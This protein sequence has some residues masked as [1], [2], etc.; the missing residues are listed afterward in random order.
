MVWD[1]HDA[2]P[3]KVILCDGIP[4][5]QQKIQLANEW[6][7]SNSENPE[8]NKAGHSWV[9]KD[10]WVECKNCL[11]VATS[12][13]CQGSRTDLQMCGTTDGRLGEIARARIRMIEDREGSPRNDKNEGDTEERVAQNSANG[14]NFNRKCNI[15]MDGIKKAQETR[16]S[17]NLEKYKGKLLEL[18]R[19]HGGDVKWAEKR[20]E[21]A[22]CQQC[23]KK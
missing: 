7:K 12:L 19:R 18:R 23:A 4:R 2:R 17:S 14:N 15:T 16:W 22:L 10:V 13:P 20:Q 5:W 9:V 8:R 1:L 11:I 21:P 6:I 3:Q